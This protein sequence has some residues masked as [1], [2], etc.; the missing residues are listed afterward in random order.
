VNRTARDRFRRTF[1][2]T[3][4]QEG[5]KACLSSTAP[6]ADTFYAA[7]VIC[8]TEITRIARSE[9]LEFIRSLNPRPTETPDRLLTDG[10]S[11]TGSAPPTHFVGTRLIAYQEL[12][13]C[14]AEQKE[15]LAAGKGRI[16]IDYDVSAEP[17]AP[18][19]RVRAAL[20]ADESAVRTQ[21]G[22]RRIK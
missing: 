7:S 14:E 13:A 10:L 15:R 17:L 5:F 22:L 11:P 9:R 8:D 4:R 1:R 16:A 21:L 19:A 18:V 6:N 3:I 12:D 2:R 20:Q